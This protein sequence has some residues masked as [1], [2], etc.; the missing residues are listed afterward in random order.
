VLRVAIFGQIAKSERGSVWPFMVTVCGSQRPQHLNS[1]K[2][3]IC[4]Q[5]SPL[6]IEANMYKLPNPGNLAT[7]FYDWL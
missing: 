2:E 5:R 3:D 4:N 7:L 6:L 1:N